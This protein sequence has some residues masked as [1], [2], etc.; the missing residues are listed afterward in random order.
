MG[1][2]SR[3]KHSQKLKDLNVMF[4]CDTKR[5]GNKARNESSQSLFFPHFY[6]FM[7]QQNKL[8]HYSMKSK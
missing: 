6:L 4:L 8:K 3:L 7:L 5:L 2:S 1:V